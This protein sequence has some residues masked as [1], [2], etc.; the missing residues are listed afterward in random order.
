MAYETTERIVV[1][2]ASTVAPRPEVILEALPEDTPASLS[3]STCRAF[4]GRF[5]RVWTDCAASRQ[6]G[7]V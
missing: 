6:G 7:G 4:H 1:V 2:G 5:R 3:C